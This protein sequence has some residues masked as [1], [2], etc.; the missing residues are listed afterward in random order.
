MGH[1]ADLDML[2]DGLSCIENAAGKLRSLLPLTE[3]I[4]AGN[5]C[6]GFFNAY[7]REQHARRGSL[8]GIGNTLQVF[9]ENGYSVALGIEV[10]SRP[11]PSEV[12][13]VPQDMIFALLS[14]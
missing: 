3:S 6:R 1:Q 13:S 4:A 2:R 9:E 7:F 14:D 5:A 8:G 11:R 12:S 10:G